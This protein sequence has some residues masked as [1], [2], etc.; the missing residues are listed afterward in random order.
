M[1]TFKIKLNNAIQ[2]GIVKKNKSSFL[3]I[4][5][6]CNQIKFFKILRGLKIKWD[7]NFL[8]LSFNIKKKD[9]TIKEYFFII[10]ICD[11]I[12]T[13][14][15]IFN[16]KLLLVGQGFLIKK[17]SKANN[18]IFKL[19]NSH[20]HRINLNKENPKIE[21]KVNS[22]T[23]TEIEISGPNNVA[24]GDFGHKLK[25]LRIPDPYKGKGFLY[26]N[27]TIVLKDIKKK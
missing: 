11:F 26:K 19:G 23:K 12:Q 13:K 15:K 20:Y 18:V 10:S 9:F 7:T 14:L 3:K 24:V 8:F 2:I 4:I 21:L 5:T 17:D 25:S 16:K 6:R 22:G 1:D 27:D